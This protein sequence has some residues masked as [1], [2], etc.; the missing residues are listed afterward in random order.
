MNG[1]FQVAIILNRLVKVRHC[2][3]EYVFDDTFDDDMLL[4]RKFGMIEIPNSFQNDVFL[5]FFFI[6]AL[7][8]I[9]SNL[10]VNSF[11]LSCREF[12]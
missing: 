10:S 12:G 11:G 8:W 1:L 7:L 2:A 9:D 4:S 5:E 3:L 6:I